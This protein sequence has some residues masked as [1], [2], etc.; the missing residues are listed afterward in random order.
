MALPVNFHM[1]MVFFVYY[2][3]KRYHCHPIWKRQT[4]YLS[5]LLCCLNIRDNFHI[6]LRVPTYHK[7][8][9]LETLYIPRYFDVLTFHWYNPVS[10]LK[11][12]PLFLKRKNG[13]IPACNNGH[14]Y[15]QFEHIRLWQTSRQI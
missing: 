5:V 4:Y 9:S 14:L 1:P 15:G 6:P 12:Y 11:T 2:D 13:K 3:K 10:L 7:Q 8:A